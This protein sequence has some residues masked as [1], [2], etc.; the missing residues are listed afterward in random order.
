[1]PPLR[2]HPCTVSSVEVMNHCYESVIVVSPFLSGVFVCRGRRC[3]GHGGGF[4]QH[5]RGSEVGNLVV[6]VNTSES[7]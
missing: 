1:M 2:E 6:F 7:F 4:G 5:L 3:L